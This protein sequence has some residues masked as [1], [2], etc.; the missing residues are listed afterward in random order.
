LRLT[1]DDKTEIR[2]LVSLYNKAIDTG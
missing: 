1:D 2:E